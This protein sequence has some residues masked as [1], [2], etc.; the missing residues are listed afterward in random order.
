M[1]LSTQSHQVFLCIIAEEAACSNMMNLESTQT[2][3]VLAAP[4]VSLEHLIAQSLV[5]LLIEPQSRTSRAREGHK[6]LC[7]LSRNSCLWG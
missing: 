3:A 5:G 6:I 4:S 7:A 1:A 2:P